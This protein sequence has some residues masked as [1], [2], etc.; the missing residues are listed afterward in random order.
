MVIETLLMHLVDQ[1]AKA[2]LKLYET[3]QVFPLIIRYFLDQHLPTTPTDGSLLT[4]TDNFKCLDVS[5]DFLEFLLTSLPESIVEK[6]EEII[7]WLLRI[8]A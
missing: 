2:M 1:D 3:D 8:K 5:L 4:H 7:R 6:I